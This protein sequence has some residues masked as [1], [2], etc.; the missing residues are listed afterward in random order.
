MEEL[1]SVQM[2]W[3]TFKVCWHFLIHSDIG[4]IKNNYS[5]EMRYEQRNDHI[6][7]QHS[8]TSFSLTKIAAIWWIFF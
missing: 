7:S 2:D 6:S 3:G 4:D 5:D 8:Q 1:N